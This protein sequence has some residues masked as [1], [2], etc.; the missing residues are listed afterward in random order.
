MSLYADLGVE[1]GADAPAVR[2][3]YRGKVK[4]AHPDA[5]GKAE[6]FERL[7]KARDVLLDPKR[8]AHYD[9]TGQDEGATLDNETSMVLTMVVGLIDAEIAKAAKTGWIVIFPSRESNTS[10]WVIRETQKAVDLRGR[11]VTMDLERPDFAP[12]ALV[13][14][15]NE[16]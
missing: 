2:A 6:D 16:G 10:P 8:R 15:L 13:R 3:A 14:A 5:G 1:R 7:T 11:I 4:R 12:S 9:R